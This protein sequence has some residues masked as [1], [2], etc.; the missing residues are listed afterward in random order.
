MF[1]SDTDL[2]AMLSLA[3][4]AAR[5]AGELVR[6]TP[7]NGLQ[8]A[9]KSSPTDIVTE[10]DRASEELILKRILAARPNDGIMGEEGASRDSRSGINWLIDPIDGTVNYS[11]G[12]PNYSISIAAEADGETLIG[13]VFDPSLDE[14]FTATRGGGSILNGRRITCAS[15]PLSKAIIGTGFSYSSSRRARQAETLRPLLPAV[16]DIRRPRLG[17]DFPLLGGLWPAGRILRSGTS[18]L[19]FCR[20]SPYSGRGWGNR[21]ELHRERSSYRFRS[22]DNG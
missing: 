21:S 1:T 17:S 10:M 18:A 12:L 15:T 8:M 2:K 4:G 7:V 13:V 16:G 11:R 3:M 9:V 19:G 5:D 14:I 20:W 6:N 22:H